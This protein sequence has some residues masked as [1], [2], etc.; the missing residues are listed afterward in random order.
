MASQQELTKE[1]RRKLIRKLTGLRNQVWE[2]G[3][4]RTD[5]KMESKSHYPK[6]ETSKIAT[7]GEELHCFQFRGKLWPASFWKESRPRLMAHYASNK[8]TSEK[9]DRVA[10]KYPH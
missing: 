2:S 7:T 1:W 8:Q 10:N 5:W 3:A 4:A 9:E 6:K